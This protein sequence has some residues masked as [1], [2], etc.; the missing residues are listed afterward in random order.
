MRSELIQNDPSLLQSVRERL[1]L[2]VL[3][4]YHRKSLSSNAEQ[5]YKET[6]ALVFSLLHTLHGEV[7]TARPTREDVSAMVWSAPHMRLPHRAEWKG[8]GGHVHAMTSGLWVG[9]PEGPQCHAVVHALVSPPKKRKV[10][11]LQKAVWRFVTSR[12]HSG[13]RGGRGAHDR[14]LSLWAPAHFR[15]VRD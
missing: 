1:P 4:S 5:E 12:K 13:G 7:S 11:A 8:G 14:F 2:D 15:F 9:Q 3:V 6:R 10:K